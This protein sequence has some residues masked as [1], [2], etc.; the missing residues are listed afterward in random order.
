MKR[1]ARKPLMHP[2]DDV[3]QAQ[4]FLFHALP[5]RIAFAGQRK[6]VREFIRRI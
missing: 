4:W 2:A 3:V 6:V 5:S 1:V